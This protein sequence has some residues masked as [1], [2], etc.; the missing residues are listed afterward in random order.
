MR[1]DPLDQEFHVPANAVI[2]ALITAAIG[3]L[4]W[5]VKVAARQTL[6]GFQDS[7]A[8]HTK[9]IEALTVTVE[10]HRKEMSDLRVVQAD[11]N[12]RLKALEHRE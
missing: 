3:V 8:T 1:A 4:G 10:A 6:A 12:A 11:F 9:A 7:L 5:I 2:G